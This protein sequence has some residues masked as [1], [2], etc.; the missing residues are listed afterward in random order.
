MRRKKK[1]RLRPEEK[2]NYSE[3]NM[4]QRQST[5]FFVRT[6]LGIVIGMLI[7]F[8]SIFI[9]FHFIYH[10]GSS[11]RTGGKSNFE[12]Y[13]PYYQSA[14]ISTSAPENFDAIA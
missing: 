13:A 6:I 14:I 4:N 12:N 10:V 5:S 7:A 8:V 3:M 11:G 9:C 2:A 1:R